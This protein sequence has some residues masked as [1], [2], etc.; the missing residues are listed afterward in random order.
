MKSKAPEAGD[1][2]VPDEVLEEVDAVVPDDLKGVGRGDDAAERDAGR[3]G[4]VGFASLAADAGGLGDAGAESGHG[5]EGLSR[6]RRGPRPT[7]GG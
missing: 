6:W 1:I 7:P 4:A 3:V 5:I 2:R